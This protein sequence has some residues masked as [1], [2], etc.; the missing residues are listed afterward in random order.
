MEQEEYKDK[1]NETLKK[2]DQI[3]LEA[4]TV[5]VGTKAAPPVV[6]LPEETAGNLKW[7]N[8]KPQS[9]L[10]PSYL[11]KEATHLE[12][13]QFTEAFKNYILDGY[14]G[15]PPETGVAIQ[16][17]PL[18]NP[19]WKESLRQKGI[20]TK[21]LPQILT[22][23]EE[24]SADR[25]LVHQRRMQSLG[26]KKTGN[27]SNF[28]FQ[29]EQSISLIEFEDLTKESLLTHLFIEQA[30]EVMSRMAQ[31][32]LMKNP[33]GDI[34]KLRQEIKCTESSTWY[35]NKRVRT[36]KIAQGWFCPD[37]N[38]TTHDLAT[39][40]GICEHCKQRGHMSERCR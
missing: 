33:K 17:Q 23:I 27:H 36:S 28:L 26:T 9:S 8:F 7:R 25:N 37:C 3:I 29:L 31:E 21:T 15:Y 11:E 20:E 24:E 18:I 1:H 32:L 30:D 4:D 34:D 38:S 22:M 10:K 39:C 12:T 14:S 13:I 19:L 40:W 35:G 5:L 6:T 2:N 16:L